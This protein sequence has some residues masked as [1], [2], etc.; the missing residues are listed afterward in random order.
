MNISGNLVRRENTILG[1]LGSIEIRFWNGCYG[2]NIQKIGV[3]IN[4]EMLIN[5]ITAVN[6]V[7]AIAIKEY[8][9][10]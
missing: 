9:F 8:P 5:A 3:K 1:Q 4:G 7:V 2:Y 10:T 6:S